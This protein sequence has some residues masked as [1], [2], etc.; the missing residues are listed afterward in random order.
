MG[1]LG[2]GGAWVMRGLGDR[3]GY[4]HTTKLHHIRNISS[5]CVQY[6]DR[7]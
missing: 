2:D 5:D 6:M 4:V 1:G 3:L 7:M